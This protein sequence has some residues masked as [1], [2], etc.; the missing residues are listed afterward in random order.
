MENA[1]MTRNDSIERLPA[2]SELGIDLMRVT[3]AQRIQSLSLPV[4]CFVAF[5]LLAWSDRWPL[6]I[7]ATMVMS[8]VTYGSISHDLVHRT[9]GL[10]GRLN[11]VFLSMIELLAVRSGHAYQAA[12]LHH[13]ARFPHAD[14]VEGSAARMSLPRTLLEGFVFQFR[15][16]F[17]ALKY[18]KKRR[19]WIIFE[20]ASCVAVVVAAALSY[21]V[22]IAP[23]AYVCLMIAGS[24]IIPLITSY[25]PH[26]AKATDALHQTRAFRGWMASVIALDHLYHLEHHLYPG[27]PHHHWPSLARRLDPYL[28]AAGIRPLKLWF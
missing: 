4:L 3:A 2:L 12:H 24:W 16:Y 26:D 19:A 20:G 11:D 21:P 13:H 23:A 1:Q 8:F 14:D 9:L 15:I 7:L 6:A 18:A 10:P 22:T 25:I 27:V 28:D 17:W 5:W